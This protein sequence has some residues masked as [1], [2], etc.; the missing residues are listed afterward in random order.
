M[1]KFRVAQPYL[2]IFS[3]PAFSNVGS[4]GKAGFLGGE[5][6]NRATYCLFPLKTKKNSITAAVALFYLGLVK[7]G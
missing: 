5:G 6:R 4:G 1:G 3:A 7:V 2:Y